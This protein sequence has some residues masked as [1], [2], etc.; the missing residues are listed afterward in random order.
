MP[1]LLWGRGARGDAVPGADRGRACAGE[2]CEGTGTSEAQL[3]PSAPARALPRLQPDTCKRLFRTACWQQGLHNGV[4]THL[5][6]PNRPFDWA[7]HLTGQQT[8]CLSTPHPKFFE[9]CLPARWLEERVRSLWEHPEQERM[10]Q[11]SLW[12]RLLG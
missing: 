7:R 6:G 9:H 10:L 3:S 11:R 8:C 5:Q 2:C 1:A 4:S 12:A